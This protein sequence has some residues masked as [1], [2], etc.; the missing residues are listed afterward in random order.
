MKN[1]KTKK[2][3]YKEIT[4]DGYSGKYLVSC[5]DT[6]RLKT[7][8]SYYFKKLSEA[9]KCFWDLVEIQEEKMNYQF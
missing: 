6:E 1:L 7:T 9:K 4:I 2:I 3:N 8:Y 5:F